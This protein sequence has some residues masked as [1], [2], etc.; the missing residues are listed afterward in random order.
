MKNENE[1]LEKQL[2]IGRNSL[3][4]DFKNYDPSTIQTS[5]EIMKQRRDDDSLRDLNFATGIALYTLADDRTV[6]LSI[7]KIGTVLNNDNLADFCHALMTD[8]FYRPSAR[9][10]DRVLSDDSTFTINDLYEANVFEPVM[11]DWFSSD[12]GTG[13]YLEM[14]IKTDA[15]NNLSE[16]QRALAEA[17]YGSGDDFERNMEMLS[18]VGIKTTAISTLHPYKIKKKHW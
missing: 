15:H 10:V 6:N 2:T 14:A 11:C 18:D 8:N 5:A 9:M 1:N 4:R 3:A 12:T 17:V 13:L 7:A 16:E